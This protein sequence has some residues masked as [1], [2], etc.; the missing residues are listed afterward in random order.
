MRQGPHR[1]F[2]E[3]IFSPSAKPAAANGLDGAK[4]NANISGEGTTWVRA[5]KSV[6]FDGIQDL[7]MAGMDCVARDWYNETGEMLTVTS[8]TDSTNIHA[9]GQYS[10]AGGYKLDIVSPKLDTPDGRALF[11]KIAAKY[12]VIVNDEYENPSPNSTGG[13]MDCSFQ[14]CK[15]PI[16]VRADGSRGMSTLASW[17]DQQDI[18][19]KYDAIQKSE[20]AIKNARYNKIADDFFQET[21]QNAQTGTPFEKAMANAY[22]RAGND[23]TLLKALPQKVHLIYQG[24]ANE[25]GANGKAAKAGV[26]SDILSSINT[27][28]AAGGYDTIDKYLNALRAR[29]ATLAQIIEGRQEY[30]DFERSSG[31]YAFTKWSI[32]V[33]T[34]KELWG[35]TLS[36]YPSLDEIHRA[37]RKFQGAMRALGY[38]ISDYRIKYHTD[39]GYDEYWEMCKDVVREKQVG[40]YQPHYYTTGSTATEPLYGIDAQLALSGIKSAVGVSDSQAEVVFEGGVTKLMGTNELDQ[41]KKGTHDILVK[42][43]REQINSNQLNQD[44]AARKAGQTYEITGGE[45]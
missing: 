33:A 22:A 2:R 12:G 27:V 21:Y 17:Q 37:N 35:C 30:I 1:A 38:K 42:E 11:K 20:N 19:A 14:N 29:G 5:D 9:A 18:A 7:T 44:Y 31:K 15:L 3:I 26:P 6:S 32:P 39:P 41:Y 16:Q 4:G 23:E 40:T 10:H 24:I 13:H 36:K 43:A 45:D 8:G 28:L 34:L 25:S